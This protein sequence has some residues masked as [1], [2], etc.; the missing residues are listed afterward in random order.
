MKY[1]A[2]ESIRFTLLGM[3]LK[4]ENMAKYNSELKEENKSLK[5]H[6]KE[7]ESRNL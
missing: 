4:I 7:V 3:E 2:L 1:E 6:I 5:A